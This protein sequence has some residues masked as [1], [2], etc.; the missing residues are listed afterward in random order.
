MVAKYLLDLAQYFNEFYH[1]CPVISELTEVMQARLL[2]VSGVKQV[3]ANGLG[4]LGI[5]APEEM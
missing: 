3:L 4:L 5:A 2:L 1:N